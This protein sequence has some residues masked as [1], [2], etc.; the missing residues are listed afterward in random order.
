MLDTLIQSSDQGFS[1]L[2]RVFRNEEQIGVVIMRSGEV[3]WAVS[4]FQNEHLGS[5]L[6]RLGQISREQLQDVERQYLSLAKT[7]KFG[8]LLEELGL[9]TRTQLK[10][11]IKLHI[12]SALINLMEMPEVVVTS[13]G[14]DMKVDEDL[15]FAI[16]EILPD[17]FSTMDNTEEMQMMASV[18]NYTFVNIRSSKTRVDSLFADFSTMPGYRYAVI[19]D[20]DGNVYNSHWHESLERE[21]LNFP[22]F[23]IKSLYMASIKANMGSLDYTHVESDLGACVLKMLHP[24]RHLFLSVMFEKECKLGVIRHKIVSAM[25]RL[26]EFIALTAGVEV[27]T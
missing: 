11:F 13:S 27:L 12:R 18:E 1:G 5:F 3:A 15:T 22:L 23:W 10:F 7:K 17:Y 25:P 6:E 14:G 26:Q 19:A 4:K 24:S 8:A 16:Q 2:I 9:L 21:N 20:F